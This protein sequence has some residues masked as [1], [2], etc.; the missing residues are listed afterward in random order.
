MAGDFAYVVKEIE[1]VFGKDHI[2]YWVALNESEFNPTAESG[3]GPVGVFQIAGVTWR[4]HKCAGDRYNY[5]DNIACAKII[6]DANGLTD[7]RWSKDHGADGG[8]G[9]RL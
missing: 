6:Y 8:W 5:K 4:H 1:R 9:K 3:T 7:W 2:M